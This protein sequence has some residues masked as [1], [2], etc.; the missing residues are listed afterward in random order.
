MTTE[1]EKQN[2]NEINL[3]KAMEDKDSKRDLM[4]RGKRVN[5]ET[6]IKNYSLSELM[7][8]DIEI[9]TYNPNIDWN[10]YRDYN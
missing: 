3:K 4:V 7:Y 1:K 8:G 6:N 2:I 9:K 5:F 10:T